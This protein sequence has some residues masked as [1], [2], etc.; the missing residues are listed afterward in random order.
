MSDNLLFLC[1]EVPVN[2]GSAG[3]IRNLRILEVLSKHFDRIILCCH[4]NNYGDNDLRRLNNIEVRVRNGFQDDLPKILKQHQFKKAWI[5]HNSLG[6][7]IDIIRI[8]G[9]S[10]FIGLINHNQ[11][12]KP[13]F[14][15][16]SL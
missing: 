16:M 6:F 2:N 12:Q 3:N 10:V 4:Q 11:G 9:L 13:R 5:V 1:K 14:P 8:L 7:Y 15:S